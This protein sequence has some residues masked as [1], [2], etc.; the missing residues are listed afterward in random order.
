MP[1]PSSV[2]APAPRSRQEQGNR[3]IP[4][5]SQG[6]RDARPQSQATSAHAPII[7][8]VP[9]QGEL[10]IAKRVYK[11]CP[12]TVL[13]HV[14]CVDLIE[15]D[16]VDFDI[17]WWSGSSVTPKSHFIA[18]LKATKLISKGCIHHLVRV[19]DLKSE[20]LTIQFVSIVNE[21]LD[22]FPKYLPG[23]PPDREIEFGIDFLSGTQPISI[24]SHR[25]APAELKE[26]K[27]QLKDLLDKGFIRP[28]VSPWGAPIL[29]MRKKDGTL[30]MCIDYHQL[31]KEK[32]MVELLKDYNMSVFYHPS[33]ANIVADA[34]SRLSMGSVAHVE[35][36]K[37]ELARD[38]HHLVKEKQD[39]D[40]SLVRLKESDKDQKVKVEHQRL[41]GV[42]QEFSIPT[43]KWEE[44]NMDFVISLPPSHRHHDSIWVVTDG[45][46]ERTIQTL[47]DM[48]RACAFDFKG[49]WNDHLLLIEFT[50]NNSFHASIQ[51]A[52]FEA[53]YGRRCRSPI[54]WFE[55]GE[56]AVI[57]LD[58]VF[59]AMEKFKLIR[60]R[61][62][63]AQSR[64]KSYA[65]VRRK[66]I[67]FN[68]NDLMYL[69]VS[70]MK[71]VKRFR[72]K[73][74]LSP[75]YV[76]PYN[77]LSR[78]GKVA[79]EVELPAELSSIHPVFHVS[80]LKKCIG[81]SVMVDS[82]ERFRYSA[83]AA[84]AIF[85]CLTTFSQ[86]S[87]K[88]SED[89]GD[90][91]VEGSKPVNKLVETIRSAVWSCSKPSLRTENKLREA[92]EKL[93]ERLFVLALYV[94][95]YIIT[96]M[97]TGVVMFVGF[98]LSGVIRDG[99]KTYVFFYPF[100]GV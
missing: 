6:S 31:N 82:S 56:T 5:R 32:K 19:K 34:L 96:M 24:P 52:P 8:P 59:E 37:K 30:R 87:F 69:K 42:M 90:Y 27:E 62:K 60:E 63:I 4:S 16:M 68:I 36:D 48:L 21:F 47:E 64:Q 3:P 54:G 1:A 46:A 14:I 71:G 11:K 18:Y 10:I 33:K 35:N 29:F 9:P 26:L 44:V 72:K 83:T 23:V 98:Q 7:C 100:D 51:M 81:D 76:G 74:K 12:I 99:D 28:S 89:A 65:D 22:V 61:L 40:P 25:M 78:V 57:G 53:L 55:V 43:W 94:G 84:L 66:D 91:H 93:E 88:S 38:V 15:L 85:E 67:E 20:T 92:M 17:F 70:P 41:G 86:W 13:H 80:M 95:R 45:Q 73:G 50:Y 2:S 49:S 97:S 58:V 39:K 79:Y 77:I 75:R